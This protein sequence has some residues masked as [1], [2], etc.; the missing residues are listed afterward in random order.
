[1]NTE[2]NIKTIHRMPAEFLTRVEAALY[3]RRS[4]GTLANWA[5]KRQGPIFH[6]LLGGAVVYGAEDL[7]DWLEVQRVLPSAA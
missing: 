5:T 1:M 4:P 6:R 3:L 7:A 2:R